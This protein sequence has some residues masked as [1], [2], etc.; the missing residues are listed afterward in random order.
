MKFEF[1]ASGHRNITCTNKTNIAFTTDNYLTK[2]GDSYAGVSA[3]HSLQDLGDFKSVLKTSKIAIT[4]EANGKEEIIVAYGNKNLKLSDPTEIIIRKS[5]YI[6]AKT[7]CVK[8]NKA[9]SDLNRELIQNL[10]VPDTKITVVLEKI[11]ISAIIFDFDNTIEDWESVRKHLDTKLEKFL[12]KKFKDDA[13]KIVEEINR[14]DAKYSGHSLNPKDLS[15][16]KW[17][18]EA[19]SNLNIKVDA[20]YIKKLVNLY[21]KTISSKV[22]LVSKAKETLKSL[23]KMKIKLALI[24][25]SDGKKEIK[26]KRIKKLGLNKLFDVILTSDDVGLNKPGLKI[27]EKTLNELDVNPVECIMVG[28]RPPV[29][30]VS[31]KKLALTT[32][33]LKHGKWAEE[34]KG[35]FSCVDFSTTQIRDVLNILKSLN[36]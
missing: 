4:I 28:N 11:P 3:S 26:M 1:R 17:F 5:N 8:A 20:D 9:A 14:I 29:D 32:I 13:K 36:G 15:R 12:N 19:F 22:R 10:Q 25:D 33:W 16:D 31:A 35:D 7:L 24:S 6:D 27:F 30:L 2:G 21:W 34:H 18:R 23:K